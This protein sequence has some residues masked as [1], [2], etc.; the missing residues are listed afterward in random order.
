MG[1]YFIKVLS[2][3]YCCALCSKIIYKIK[4][5]INLG[6]YHLLYGREVSTRFLVLYIAEGLTHV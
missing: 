5:N 2:F 4:R 3:I 1:F 6:F